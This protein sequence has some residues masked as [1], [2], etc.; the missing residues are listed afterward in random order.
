MPLTCHECGAPDCRDLFDRL[1][2]LEFSRPDPYGRLHAVTVPAWFLQHPDRAPDGTRTDHWAILQRWQ[3]DGLDGVHDVV[4]RRRV[5][6]RRGQ[7]LPTAMDEPV[8]PVPDQVSTAVTIGHV[9]GPGR[10]FPEIG[11]AARVA[12]WLRAIATS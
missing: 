2:A 5:A 8:P 9:A 6:N 1:L 10:D 12:D 4:R 7:D 11:H 3:R